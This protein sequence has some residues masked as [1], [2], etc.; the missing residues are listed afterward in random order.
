MSRD[1]I[2]TFAIKSAS[3]TKTKRE[4]KNETKISR[5]CYAVV[6]K[7]ENGEL[8]ARIDTLKEAVNE[9][10]VLPFTEKSLDLKDKTYVFHKDKDKYNHY[11]CEIRDKLTAAISYGSSNRYSVFHENMLI[12]GHI[13]RK[14]GKMYFDYETLVKYHYDSNGTVNEVKIDTSKPLFKE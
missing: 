10:I 13:V 3:V 14:N 12:A 8:K 6:I 1:L 4:H 9:Y 7:D 11:V 5:K 2:F